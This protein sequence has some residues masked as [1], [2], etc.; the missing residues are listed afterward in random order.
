MAILVEP[1]TDLRTLGDIVR[2]HDATWGVSLEICNLLKNSTACYLARREDGEV[3]GYAFVEADPARGFCE[4]QDLAVAED[5]QHRG[6]GQ[7]LMR[8]V[9]AAHH[10]VKLIARLNRERLVRIYEALGFQRT[11]VIENYYGI[12]EDGLR[13][14]FEGPGA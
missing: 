2:L 9:M 1:F 8:T 3:C 12:G 4:I 7:A 5:M 13:M 10:P 6:L 11:G 14:T